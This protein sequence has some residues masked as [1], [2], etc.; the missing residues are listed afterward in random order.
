MLLQVHDEL[1]FECAAA[2]AKGLAGLARQVIEGAYRLDAP[3]VA[4]ARVGRNW[5]EMTPV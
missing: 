5:D 4:D 1:V 2:D 3:L